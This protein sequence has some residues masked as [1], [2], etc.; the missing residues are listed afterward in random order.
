MMMMME[1]EHDCFVCLY[2]FNSIVLVLFWNIATTK[3]VGID[4]AT[5]SDLQ[6]GWQ[7]R[8]SKK[9]VDGVAAAWTSFLIL[10][11]VNKKLKS[12]DSG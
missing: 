11:V 5:S 12:M 2:L 4:G 8:Q 10:L 3:V 6:Q 7:S 1:Q 9:L